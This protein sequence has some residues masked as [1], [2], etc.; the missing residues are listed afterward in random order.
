M[1][2]VFCPL[3]TTGAGETAFQATGETRLAVDCKLQPQALVGHVRITFAPEEV[4][5]SSGALTGGNKRLNT[6]PYPE[7]P[8]L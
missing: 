8:P 7:L 2:T 6:V 3:T 5:V 4:M 1:V